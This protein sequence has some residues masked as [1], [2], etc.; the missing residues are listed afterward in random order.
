MN[1]VARKCENCG[2]EFYIKD[3]LLKFGAGKVCS[4]K[5]Q[6]EKRT[7]KIKTTCKICGKFFYSQPYR[8]GK[9]RGKYC[10]KE[11]QHQSMKKVI[12]L[13]CQTCGCSFYK[14][15]NQSHIKFCSRKCS[16]LSIR[17]KNH[18]MYI[19]GTPVK[20]YGGNWD[21]QRKL[22]EKRDNYKCVACGKSKNELPPRT[23]HVHHKIRR[24]YFTDEE[25]ANDLSNLVTLCIACHRKAE[26][27]RI[28]L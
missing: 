11:C 14:K 10:S 19:E 25:K 16:G 23:L 3:I 9:E 22:A 24:R 2:K 6:I 26:D 7:T 8:F 15:P 5:C 18:P 21:R 4:K 27:G 1:I 20:N 12:E 28:V 17:G 13:I